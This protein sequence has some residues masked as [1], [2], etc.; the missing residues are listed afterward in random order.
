MFPNWNTFYSQSRPYAYIAILQVI[1][2]K[3]WTLLC[4]LN[5]TRFFERVPDIMEFRTS[6]KCVT[7]RWPHG[8]LVW[9]IFWETAALF[10][11]IEIGHGLS[12]QVVSNDKE[13]KHDF[14]KTMPDKCWNVC[15]LVRLPYSYYTGFT[16]TTSAPTTKPIHSYLWKYVALYNGFV[17]LER[18]PLTGS[19][20]TKISVPIT[21]NSPHNG[22]VTWEMRKNNYL[23][24]SIS[25][26][27]CSDFECHTIVEN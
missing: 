26:I 13:N 17:L 22:P 4:W 5:Y 12:T 16:V 20:L 14:V 15:V 2:C 23:I 19:M 27:Y 7:K 1:L 25:G 3:Q 11:M 18:K 6:Y 10:F 9:L 8:H 24:C 21:G